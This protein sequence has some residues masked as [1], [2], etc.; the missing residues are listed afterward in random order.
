[1][2]PEEAAQLLDA[3]EGEERQLPAISA[4]GRAVGQPQTPK[5]LKDW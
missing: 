4:Q 1:M 5:N 3:L 2:T